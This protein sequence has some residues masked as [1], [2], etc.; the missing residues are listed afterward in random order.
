MSPIGW[1]SDRQSDEQSS[2]LCIRSMH[3]FCVSARVA[4]AGER[5]SRKA[6]AGVST[7]PS[8]SKI[9]GEPFNGRTAGL[10]PANGGSIPSSSTKFAGRCRHQS[11]AVAEWIGGGLWNRPRG[12]DFLRPPQIDS[13]P[14]SN[15]TGPSPPQAEIPVRIRMGRPSLSFEFRERGRGQIRCVRSQSHW[16]RLPGSRPKFFRGSQVGKAPHC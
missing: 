2:I 14:W 10:Q 11:V 3:E 13:G 5:R 4:Q 16:V 7:T 9:L 8:G 1:A 12:F 15:G 6:E